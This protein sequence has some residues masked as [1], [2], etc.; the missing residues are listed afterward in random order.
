MKVNIIG[1][2]RAPG[3]NKPAPIENIELNQVAVAHIIKIRSFKVFT[4]DGNIEITKNNINDVFSGKIKP[5]EKVETPAVEENKVE[6]EPEPIPEETKV[7]EPTV[8]PDVTDK[9]VSESFIQDVEAVK[10]QLP[11]KEDSLFP[12]EDTDVES[13]NKDEDEENADEPADESAAT[14]ETE[15]PRSNKKKRNRK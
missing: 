10:D 4:A 2:G 12:I 7:E 3:I 5:A 9:E 13:F 15:K 11:E 14:D 1:K 6:V 8:S